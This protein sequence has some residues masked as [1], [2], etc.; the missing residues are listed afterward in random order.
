MPRKTFTMKAPQVRERD[1]RK[2]TYWINIGRA[3]QLED[4]R[5]ICNMDAVPTHWEGTFYLYA[6]DENTPKEHG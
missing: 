5:I 4:G 6:N 2:I 3:T 1:G